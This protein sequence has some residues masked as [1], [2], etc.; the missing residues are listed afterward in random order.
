M[1]NKDLNFFIEKYLGKE[2]FLGVHGSRDGMQ[3]IQK[4]M[5]KGINIIIFRSSSFCLYFIQIML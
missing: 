1:K 3:A 4:I 2:Y 5:T